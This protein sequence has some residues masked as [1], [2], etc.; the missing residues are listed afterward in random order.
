MLS[1]RAVTGGGRPRDPGRRRERTGVPGNGPRIA[2]C[3]DRHAQVVIGT[4]P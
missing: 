2:V 1:R 4:R 3:E